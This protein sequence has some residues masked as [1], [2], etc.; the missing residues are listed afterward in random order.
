MKRS[1]LVGLLAVLGVGASAASAQV[2]PA[3]SVVP[4]GFKIVTDQKIGPAIIAEARKA[5]DACPKQHLDP[6][7]RAGYSWQPNPAAQQTV[8]IIAQQ[9]EEP[10]GRSMGMTRTEPAGKLP[11]RGGVLTWTKTV[12]PWIG[13]GSAPDLVTIDGAWVGAAAGGLLGVSVGGFCGTKE[14]ALAWLDS[15]LDKTI[16]PTQAP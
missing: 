15:M 16:G 13:S 7:I 14:A 12:T 11:H 4:P 5:N 9:P 6:E 1:F 3:A 2:P 8:A 10:A